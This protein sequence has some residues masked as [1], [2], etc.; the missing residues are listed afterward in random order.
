[1]DPVR[2]E[3]TK[4]ESIN[5]ASDKKILD[6]GTLPRVKIFVFCYWID[7]IPLY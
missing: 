4:G 7:Y 5:N 6:L 1:M 2:I 3:M